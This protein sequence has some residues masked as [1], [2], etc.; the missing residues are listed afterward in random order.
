MAK[1]VA[2]LVLAGEAVLA[3]AGCSGGDGVATL[4]GKGKGKEQT[5]ADG[6]R[7]MV[8]C[9]QD[10]GVAAELDDET[11]GEGQASFNVETD[12]AYA[13]G[14]GDGSSQFYAGDGVETAAEFEAAEKRLNE[15]VAKYD[16]SAAGMSV[17]GDGVIS[18]ETGEGGGVNEDTGEAIEAEPAATAAPA[19]PAASPTSGEA[20]GAESDDEGEVVEEEDIPDVP[21]YLIVGEDDHS[22]L[23]ATCLEESGYTQPEY[24]ID[25]AEE[26]KEKQASLEA[27]NKWIGC[28]RENGYP[29]MAD[30]A[31]PKADEYQTQPMAILPADI[32]EADL[33]ALLKACP[34]FDVE[35]HKAADL[36]TIEVLKKDP[37][38]SDSE[39]MKFYEELAKKHPGS[40]DPQ[41]G[42]DAP[43][44]NGNMGGAAGMP[45]DAEFERLSKLQ[46]VLYEA[47]SAYYEEM[48]PK[49]QE[50]EG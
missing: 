30:P 3:L 31:P 32:T 5:Q 12:K 40:I 6:A 11:W 41:I 13:I 29:D 37:N 27:T 21:P 4:G 45:E 1:R 38:M 16:P 34:N 43:G 28:A 7:A 18:M 47:M 22:E 19:A 2:R 24:K 46:E 15:L 23:F 14:Y 50:I 36:E 44:F 35:D 8:K 25:P 49:F 17:D 42:F 20:S 26:I 39:T 10:G 33:R 48:A 9:L